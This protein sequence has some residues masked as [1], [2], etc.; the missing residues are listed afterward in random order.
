LLIRSYHP[1]KKEAKTEVKKWK[2]QGL[3]SDLIPGDAELLGTEMSFFVYTEE[4]PKMSFKE[5]LSK[6]N[7][8]FFGDQPTKSTETFQEKLARANKVF[9]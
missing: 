2:K 9:E 4:K 7:K 5:K 6:A 3:T 1:T 8:D